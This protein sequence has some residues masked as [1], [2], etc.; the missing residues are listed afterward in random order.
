MY[1]LEVIQ[2][3]R[4]ATQCNAMWPLPGEPFLYPFVFDQAVR[5]A[6]PVLY[7]DVVDAMCVSVSDTWDRATPE[8][9]VLI[10]GWK[11]PV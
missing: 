4:I 2:N 10:G 11:F 6:P 8:T 7:A 9:R 5:A 3:P 1:S